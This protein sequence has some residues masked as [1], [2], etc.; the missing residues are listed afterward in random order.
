MALSFE[1]A[2]TNTVTNYQSGRLRVLATTG[3]VRVPILS[4]IPTV[5]ESGYPG[6]VAQ[7]WFGFFGP[8]GLPRE[9][10]KRV[11]E[12]A[13]A[14]LKHKLVVERYEKLVRQADPL[15]PEQFVRFL[16]EQGRIWAATA[17]GLNL[18][19]E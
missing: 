9:I 11:N 7:G 16:Q 10:T 14:L 18:Q 6:F 17:K 2:L 19:L 8:A 4:G 13:R 15:P 12:I 1:S 3:S 5:A